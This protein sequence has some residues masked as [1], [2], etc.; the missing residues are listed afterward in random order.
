MAVVIPESVRIPL[1]DGQWIEV[2]K[3]LSYGEATK[4]RA[5]A[6]TKEL[7]SKG[8]LQVDMEQIGKIQIM[9]YLLNWSQTF[10]GEPIPIHTPELLSSALDNQDEE[11]VNDITEAIT[12]HIEKAKAEKNGQA[13]EK[14]L[15][16]RSPSAA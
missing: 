1:R 7:G 14:K 6:F 10:N 13:G 4:A 11:T 12:A 16:R 9:S 5:K 3:R 8:Q 15:P 2:R